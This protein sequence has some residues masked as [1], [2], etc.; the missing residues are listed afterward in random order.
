[1]LSAEV[2]LAGLPHVPAPAGLV[3][4]SKAAAWR[5]IDDVCDQPILFVPGIRTLPA[6]GASGWTAADVM[7]GEECET[8]GAWRALRPTGACAFLWPGSHTKLVMVDSAGRI[9]CSYTTLAGE[10]TAAV[11]RH[12]LVSASLSGEWPRVLDNDAV[13]GGASVARLEG[14]GR[15]AFLVRVAQLSDALDAPER[16]AFWI[17]AVIADDAMRLARSPALEGGRPLFVGG[18]Q[19]QRSL[20][21]EM[22]RQYV[23][24]VAQELDD[25][26]AETASALGAIAVLDAAGAV[27]HQI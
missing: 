17:G 16:W 10:L 25:E 18:R 19:P 22:I 13:R 23:P 2:G 6:P 4:L 24:A 11:A 8:L 12:T 27:T 9:E 21:A 5:R 3:E 26:L 15:A 7:R 14:L 1:M 20:Y